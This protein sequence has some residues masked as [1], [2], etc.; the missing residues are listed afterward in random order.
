M[1][2]DRSCN[3]AVVAIIWFGNLRGFFFLTYPLQLLALC[4]RE[5]CAH[6]TATLC[7]HVLSLPLFFWGGWTSTMVEVISEEHGSVPVHCQR[8]FA[9]CTIPNAWR[10][11]PVP[12]ESPTTPWMKPWSPLWAPESGY[13]DM[14]VVVT[15]GRGRD[16]KCRL[17]KSCRQQNWQIYTD[18]LLWI[19]CLWWCARHC[20]QATFRKHDTLISTTTFPPP[21]LLFPSFLFP[22]SSLSFPSPFYS[23]F[24]PFS[25]AL[26]P[27]TRLHASESCTITW[28]GERKLCTL[29][30]LLLLSTLCKWSKIIPRP[31]VSTL[32]FPVFRY[33]STPNPSISS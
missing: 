26:H 2:N 15:A 9:K 25:P 14:A 16:D 24:P 33:H 31:A 30:A 19:H 22:P 17:C 1:T 5:A 13:Q 23:L 18:C 20:F 6:F 3:I 4:P 27:Q 29:A 28:A 32:L 10:W 8:Y 11:V 12:A 7:S 21:L